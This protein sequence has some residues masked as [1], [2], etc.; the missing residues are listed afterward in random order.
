MYTSNR[1]SFFDKFPALDI[2][3]IPGHPNH[4]A[5]RMVCAVLVF[6]GDP[7]FAIDHVETF[8]AHASKEKVVHQDVLMLL[9][10]GSLSGHNSWL[11]DHEPKK[12]LMY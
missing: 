2:A 12:H 6:D 11:Y 4:V 1:L 3:S 10:M 8:N 5:G 7:L 9:F